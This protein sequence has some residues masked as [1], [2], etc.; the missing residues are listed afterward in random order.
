MVSAAFLFRIIRRVDPNPTDDAR[1]LREARD[2]A[3]TLATALAGDEA[4]LA[5]PWPAVAPEQ[6]AEGRAALAEM[7]AAVSQ[8]ADSL[9][10]A[11]QP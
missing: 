9:D 1:L 11:T 6:L 5:Q 8:L 4:D 10:R 2:H 3:R 7:R